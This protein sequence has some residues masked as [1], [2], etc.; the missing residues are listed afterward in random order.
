MVEITFVVLP[1]RFD[2]LLNLKKK[3]RQ[4]KG[5]KTSAKVEHNVFTLTCTQIMN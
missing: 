2:L 3:K 1:L 4:V 5:V